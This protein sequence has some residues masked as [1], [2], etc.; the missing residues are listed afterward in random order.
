MSR[1]IGAHANL[2]LQD[3]KSVIY[4]YGGC[5]LNEEKFRNESHI[6]DGV[7]TVKTSC[8]LEPTIHKKMKRLPSGRKKLIIK[9]IPV[10]VDYPKMVRD[11][12]ITIK[13]CSNCWKVTPD[14]HVE[15][16]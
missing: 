13:N 11:G 1:G 6:Y 10:D 12:L 14:N 7:I 9:R 5:N 3:E 4:E 8:F 15:I 16:Y 2:V